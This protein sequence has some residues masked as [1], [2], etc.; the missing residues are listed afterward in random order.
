[1]K[2]ISMTDFVLESNKKIAQSHSRVECGNLI[3][4][5][6]QF[7]KQP[8]K[9]WMFVACDEE[10]NMLEEP[11]RWGD[12]LMFP[13]SFDGNKEWND[14]Y[15]YQQAKERRLFEGVTV[16]IENNTYLDIKLENGNVFRY[17]KK[18][19]RFMFC[20]DYKIE[21]LLGRDA[22]L[23]PTAIKQIGVTAN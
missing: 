21:N 19:Q 5:Y 20:H 18:E 1:M 4:N 17:V 14:L 6:A 22:T 12:Y 2:L 15:E 23:T 8:L 10:R 9:L 13:E 3:L 16:T 7:L 11:E